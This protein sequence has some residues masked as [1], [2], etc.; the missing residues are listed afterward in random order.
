MKYFLIISS[1]FLISLSFM[2]AQ[3]GPCLPD[4]EDSQWIPAHPN[5]AF[6]IPITLCGKEFFI[7]YRHRIACDIWY[8][9]YIEEIGSYENGAVR[10]CIN[11]EYNS[12]NNFVRAAVELLIT[13]NPAAFPPAP[14]SGDCETNWRVLKGSCW[15]VT[16]YT[17]GIGSP[18]LQSETENLVNS[19]GYAEFAEPCTTN[20]CCLEYFTVCDDGAGN[21]D[22]TQTGYLPP[23]D[24]ECEGLIGNDTWDCQPVCGSVYNR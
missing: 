1:I 6:E 11:N 21:R 10:D 14:G 24:P 3:D 15:E 2:N 19:Y 9:Y 8:D 16:F 17:G 7:R 23:E 13:I 20:D 4:C 12:L 22:I 18:E 5:D